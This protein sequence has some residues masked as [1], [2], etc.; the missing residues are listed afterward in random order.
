MSYQIFP[1]NSAR[2]LVEASAKTLKSRLDEVSKKIELLA[3]KGERECY[4]VD[5]FG[6]SSVYAV[7]AGSQTQAPTFTAQQL[8]VKVEL[9]K[10][11]YQ[12]KIISYPYRELASLDPEPGDPAYTTRVG[13]K[14][15]IFW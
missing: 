1:A 4:P 9:E 13:Y 15:G 14:F 7:A 11:G 6:P 2:E 3:T 12:V 5:Y 8:A 10:A